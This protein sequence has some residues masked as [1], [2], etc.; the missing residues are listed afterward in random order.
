MIRLVISGALASNRI[1]R[2]YCMS[3]PDTLLQLSNDAHF[4]SSEALIDRF[5]VVLHDLRMAGA[6]KRTNRHRLKR[7][8]EML[9]AHTIRQGREE[10]CFLDVGASDGVTT[11]DAARALRQQFGD[12]LVYLADINLRLLRHRWGPV[13]EYRA[14]N[15]EPI[16]VRIGPLGLRLAAP[17]RVDTRQHGNWLA[18]LYLRR[19]RLRCA[20]RLDARI[21]LVNPLSWAEPGLSVIELDCLRWDDRLVGRF[22]AI[23]ASNTLNLGYF[24]PAQIGQAIGHLH[25]YLRDHGCL[26]VS[27]NADGAAGE[28]EHGSVWV[29]EPDRFRWVADFGAGSEVRAIVDG[30]LA[31]DGT[32]PL[33]AASLDAPSPRAIAQERA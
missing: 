17:R 31:A 15:N 2:R 8:E 21:S 20:M 32:P 6:W 4:I 33:C 16:M 27:R 24:E 23:R 13:I 11:V 14:S 29:R 12:V 18:D 10:V 28:T 7:T 25:S 30:W 19:T 26:V 1:L 5:S 3:D 9:C 22:S